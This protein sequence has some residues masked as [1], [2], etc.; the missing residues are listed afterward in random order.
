MST[1][2]KLPTDEKLDKKLKKMLSGWRWE[3]GTPSEKALALEALIKRNPVMAGPEIKL[4]FESGDPLLMAVAT[5]TFSSW[6][7]PLP[8]SLDELNR[9]STKFYVSTAFHQAY[10]GFMKSQM[11][12]SE[13]GEQLERLR[14]HPDYLVRLRALEATPD[15]QPAWRQSIHERGWRHQ[16]APEIIETAA[17]LLH[18]DSGS[19]LWL[20]E[21]E[22]GPITI[23]LQGGYAPITCATIIYLTRKGYFDD[24]AF[25]RVVPNFVAQ[26][27][28]KA[29][30]GN[31]GP[32]FNIPCEIN[33]LR[34]RKGAVGMAHAGKDSGGSQFF[35]CH[36]DQPHLDGGH[37]LFGHVIKGFNLVGR[38]EEGT[39][40]TRA[41]VERV[42]Q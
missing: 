33:P 25:H 38:L 37:T 10:L 17:E 23:K 35:I 11:T 14:R 29:G 40:I 24:M 18:G 36:S 41:T 2:S 8:V 12:E 1:V 16:I 4:V 22:K 32:G 19:W 6:Q 15:P 21:T 26:A 3:Q 13:W 27:G 30:D 9:A 39:R 34:F 7:K 28:E 20:L 31:G 42:N 5:Q